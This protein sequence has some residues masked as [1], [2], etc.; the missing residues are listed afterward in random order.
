MSS[1]TCKKLRKPYILMENVSFSP[2]IFLFAFCHLSKDLSLSSSSFMFTAAKHWNSLPNA[3]KSIFDY[4]V[5][6]KR[7]GEYL[8]SWYVYVV[9]SVIPVVYRILTSKAP[10]A[11][12]SDNADEI[13]RPLRSCPNKA[14]LS[15]EDW[16]RRVRL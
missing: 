5:F 10:L 2:N 9:E 3:L 14:T 11:R 8:L 1:Y 7:L 13:A 4:H 12:R 16:P 6:K 15:L